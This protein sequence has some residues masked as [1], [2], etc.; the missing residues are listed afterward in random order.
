MIPK[1]DYIAPRERGREAWKKIKQFVSTFFQQLRVCFL[2][3]KVSFWQLSE[4]KAGTIENP[5]READLK[6]FLKN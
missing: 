5:T 1:V 2:I 3:I 4:S 6:I